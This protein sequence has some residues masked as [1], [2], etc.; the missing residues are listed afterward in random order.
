MPS[1]IYYATE[2][3]TASLVGAMLSAQLFNLIPNINFDSPQS[4]VIDVTSDEFETYRQVNKNFYASGD[5]S[6]CPPV[7]RPVKGGEYAGTYSIDN[8]RFG[9]L[10]EI[11]CPVEKPIPGNA[12]GLVF[13]EI[14]CPPSFWDDER[15]CKVKAPEKALQAYKQMVRGL[16]QKLVRLDVP[17]R[18]WI[19]PA[20]LKLFEGGK[21]KLL[22]KGTWLDRTGGRLRIYGNGRK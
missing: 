19:T 11:G 3:E 17:E 8:S 6:L 16:K 10:I 12:L 13:G 4:V 14:Y 7:L 21:A 22:F 15:Q 1:F 2:S 20:A 5:F 9:P 18:V